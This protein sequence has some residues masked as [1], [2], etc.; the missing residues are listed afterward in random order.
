MTQTCNRETECQ[1]MI[2]YNNSDISTEMKEH[3]CMLMLDY[4][5]L[6]KNDRMKNY[7][8]GILVSIPLIIKIIT[9]ILNKPSVIHLYFTCH[10]QN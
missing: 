6:D 1:C 3:L 5:S 8:Y 4:Y 2:E 9:I 7:S 10:V